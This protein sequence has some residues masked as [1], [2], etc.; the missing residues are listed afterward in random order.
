MEVCTDVTLFYGLSSWHG[1]SINLDI[2]NKMPKHIQKILQEEVDKTVD[3]LHK[4]QLQ[5]EDDDVQ[6]YKKLGKKIHVVPKAERE[7]WVEALAP[8]KNKQMS[9]FGE[10]GKK[11]MQIAD[12]VNARYPYT[13]RV[14]K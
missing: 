10:F 8:F 5:L 1:Y 4:T 2:W 14:I 12:D 11:I 9:G 7:K 3:W 13:D 6:A